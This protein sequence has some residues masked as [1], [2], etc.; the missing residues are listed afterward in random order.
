[1]VR[2]LKNIYKDEETLKYLY[3]Q[4][5]MTQKEIA[6]RLNM[7]RQTLVYWFNK[8]DIKT[9]GNKAKPAYHTFDQTSGYEKWRTS[10][11]YERKTVMVHHLILVAEGKDPNKVFSDQYDTH[12][13]NG[14]KFDNRPKNLELIDKK[15][16]GKLH[17]Q[18]RW[19]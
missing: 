7:P 4:K 11:N 15:E 13:K 3:K 18:Q 5:R 16:H 9:R 10:V 1:M 2:K 14:H 17:A 12:H 6:E 8:Y 19:E